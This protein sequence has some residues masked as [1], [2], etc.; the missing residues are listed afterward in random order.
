MSGAMS[1]FLV[2]LIQKYNVR[3]I[4]AAQISNIISGSLSLAPVAGAIVADAFFGCYSVIAVSSAIQ[5]LV[6]APISSQ[7]SANNGEFL[8]IW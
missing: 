1:N 4:D 3:S 7:F 5:L 2:Y 6:C 8:L